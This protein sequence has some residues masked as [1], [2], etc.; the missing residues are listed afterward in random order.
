[1]ASWLDSKGVFCGMDVRLRAILY[2]STILLAVAAP[3]RAQVRPFKDLDITLR[4]DQ[5]EYVMGQPIIL[6][7]QL[8][9]PHDEDVE[10]PPTFSWTEVGTLWLNIML[11]RDGREFATFRPAGMPL[12]DV[13]GARPRIIPAHTKLITRA[14]VLPAD[15]TSRLW[16]P[17]ALH[18]R[19]KLYDWGHSHSIASPPTKV[20]IRRPEGQ[21]A[22]ALESLCEGDLIRYL[23]D[24]YYVRDTLG[25]PAIAALTSF[26]RDHGQSV[27]GPYARF[28]LVQMH[29]YRKRYADAAEEAEALL[30]DVPGAA[31]ADEAGY[32]AAASRFQLGERERARQLAESVVRRH[33]DTPAAEEARKLLATLRDKP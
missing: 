27:Y 30:R 21:D 13:A 6:Y 25:E 9:N 7:V 32:I 28:G 19:A 11:S 18:I 17:G 10:G 2:I 31:V 14:V 24:L 16:P 3:A 5:Q 4:V 1:M 15:G 20:D 22:A 23:G 33:P 12:A 29:Y 26:V 8:R